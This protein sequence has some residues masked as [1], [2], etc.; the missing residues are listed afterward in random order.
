[1]WE[2]QS[3]IPMICVESMDDENIK[4]KLSMKRF[5]INDSPKD[6]SNEKQGMLDVRADCQ[7]ISTTNSNSM[8]DKI[9]SLNKDDIVDQIIKNQ[10]YES[11][12]LD[13][14]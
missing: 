14:S 3:S 2:K 11:P 10:K 8:S 9:R 6:I 5:K 13:E 7:S 4:L 1:M 12:L